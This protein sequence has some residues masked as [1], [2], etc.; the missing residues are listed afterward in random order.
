MRKIFLT[1]VAVAMIATGA[2]AQTE[3]GKIYVGAASNLGFNNVKYDGADKS[4]SYFNLGAKG[5]YFV[6]DNLAINLGLNFESVSGDNGSTDFGFN[7]GGR[8]YFP[9]KVFLGAMF[10]FDSF[11]PKGGDSAS[12]MGLTFEG[13]YAIFLND[14]IAIEPA[15]TYRL[16][17]SDKDKGTKFNQFG[18]NIGFGLYF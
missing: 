15:L 7:I 14:N 11:K 12:G 5:G 8:Y 4:T 17:L 3:K 1:M 9:P 2:F 10:D 6:I 13:G 18:I 16:G